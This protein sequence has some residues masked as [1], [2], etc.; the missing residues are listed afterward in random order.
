[1]A[2][3]NI[4]KPCAVR[5]SLLGVVMGLLLMMA[6]H[7]GQSENFVI[8]FPKSH[9][10]I[11][12]RTYS[13]VQYL[14][15]IQLLN[16]FGNVGSMKSRKKS[17]EVWFNSTQIR[18]RQDDR[19]IRLNNAK[20]T[21]DAPVRTIEGEWMVPAD[22]LTSVLPTLINQVVHYQRGED[23]ILV[24]NV[25]PNSFALH[26]S[27]VQNGAELSIQFTE[28]INLR[29]AA[30]NGKWVLYLGSHPVQPVESI[31][32]L[33]NPYVSQ[34]RFDDHDGQPKLIIS[35]SSPGLDFYPKLSDEGKTIIAQI[36]KPEAPQTA[37]GPQQAAPAAPVPG[38]SQPAV[39]QGGVAPAPAPA[40]LL[41]AVVLDAGHGGSDL[42]AQGKNGLLEKNLT[43]QIVAQVQRALLAT[44][45][46][47]VVLTRATD[48]NVNFDQRAVAANIARPIA[49][50]SFHA[51]DL[52]QSTPRV[53]VYSYRPSS[54]LAMANG[55]DPKS[56][57]VNWDKV[58]LHYID[59]SQRLA[60]GLQ[61]DLEKTTKAASTPPM[62]LPVRV[63]QSIAAPAVAVEVG[64]LAPS[65]DA[66][67][68]TNSN[69]QQEIAS[70]VVQAV[71]N[72]QGGRP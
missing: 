19:T 71:A 65:S 2:K 60:E 45:K 41:P 68:L 25:R 27:Q 58:Q 17:L 59:Q 23:R 30:Q 9:S 38:P 1:M 22:F 49:F 47:R 10:I 48:I 12:V 55:P 13:S 26:L 7:S 54:P 3:Y 69:F 29:T 40:P 44:G 8:Y 50:F 6:P 66:S 35:P 37:T 51:G 53:M 61:Q 70:A 64:S 5:W 36:I 14:P 20:L 15:V 39:T 31:F 63:L 33:N 67:P 18:L 62:E 28:Q 21:L 11:P 52:G 43:L 4:R 42:G 56:L 57:F 32:E 34:V 24:G 46:Y 16:L 72:L